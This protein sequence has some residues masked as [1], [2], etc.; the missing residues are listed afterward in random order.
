MK[1]LLLFGLVLWLSIGAASQSFA[2]LA[3]EYYPYKTEDLERVA[4]AYQPI[5]R[6]CSRM[7][8]GRGFHDEEL[9]K[10]DFGGPSG[11]K[12]K[13][14]VRKF[15]KGLGAPRVVLKYYPAE[16]R[17][18]VRF[19]IA[20]VPIHLYSKLVFEELRK[21]GWRGVQGSTGGDVSFKKRNV[22]IFVKGKVFHVESPTGH[23]LE[24]KGANL[25]MWT[26]K[27]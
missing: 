27:R 25:E 12:T 26:K 17:C 15:G 9:R 8:E 18:F 3:F 1:T 24:Y 14:Y 7:M 2:Q 5:I 20:R 11:N 23:V 13:R 22:T 4:V 21:L 10:N 16:N 6:V 19:D